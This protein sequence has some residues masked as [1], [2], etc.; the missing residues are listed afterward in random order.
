MDK[1]LK[2]NAFVKIMSVG[3]AV[4]LYIAV[5]D[6]PLGMQTNNQNMATVIRNVSLDA[7]LDERRF[8]VVEMPQTVNLTLSGNSF[9]LNRVAVGNYRAF[10]DLST[11]GAG[12]HINVPVRVEGLPE[13]VDYTTEPSTVRVVMEETE[14]KEVKVEAEVLGQPAEGYTVGSPAISPEKVLVRAGESRLKQ[15]A[16][17]KAMANVSGESETVKQTVELK[18]YNDAGEVVDGVEIDQPVAEIEVPIQSPSKEVLIHPHVTKLPPDGYSI[19]DVT[20]N[21]ERVL[22]YGETEVLDEL[23]VYPGPELDLSAVAKDR[24][25]E[26]QIPLIKGV[27]HVD[28]DMIEIEVTIVPSER[29]TFSDVPIEVENLPDGWTVDFGSD[30]EETVPVILEGAPQRLEG[31]EKGD[32]RASIDVADLKPGKHEVDIQWSFPDYI[33]GLETK[34]A[35]NIE[36]KKGA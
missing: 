5:N 9:L 33:K 34:K 31:I 8:T 22:V 10:V 29:K 12:V 11:Y 27:D 19:Q 25:Y 26:R 32:I 14:Q 6:T 17:V 23:E 7:E 16:V 20:F 2:S 3:L 13:G 1:W 24:T 28:P 15:V 35:V 30:Q 4:L 36:L 18:A 21:Q